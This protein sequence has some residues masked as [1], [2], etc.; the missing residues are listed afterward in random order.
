MVDVLI[1]IKVFVDYHAN[2][3]GGSYFIQW[4]FIKINGNYLINIFYSGLS[5]NDHKMRF[6]CIYEK[7]VFFKP[8][9]DK[10]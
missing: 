7:P 2:K 8:V 4:F 3:L 5:S 9:R 10:D 1:K 6:R